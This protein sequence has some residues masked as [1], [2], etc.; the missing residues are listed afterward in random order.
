MGKRTWS[1]G[2]LLMALG[3]GGDADLNTGEDPVEVADCECA[4]ATK[5]AN[6][7]LCISPTTAFSPA[8]VYS[9]SWNV[10]AGSPACEPWRSPQPLPATPWSTIQVSSKCAGTGQ[11]CITVRS[12]NAAQPL[13][14]DCSLARVCTSIDYAGGEQITA[15][16]PLPSW[17]A[18][19]SDCAQRYERDGGYL[20][21]VVESEQLGCNMGSGRR[22]LVPLCPT[23]CEA[24]PKGAGCEICGNGPEIRF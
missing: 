21:F 8:H 18:E 3:C 22:K 23:R 12:G 1:L 15:L 19:S 24:D 16:A 5:I 14:D 4:V 13:P 17:V 20:E 7:A 6:L 11:F 10:E 9:S 2:L